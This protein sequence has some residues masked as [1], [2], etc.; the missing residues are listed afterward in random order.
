LPSAAFFFLARRGT[1]G[2]HSIV[3]LYGL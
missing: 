2:T 3:I 1:A